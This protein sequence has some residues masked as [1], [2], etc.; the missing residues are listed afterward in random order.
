MIDERS[1]LGAAA[2]G[3]GLARAIGLHVGLTET[4]PTIEGPLL[5]DFH[6]HLHP[7]RIF[8]L[9]NRPFAAAIYNQ[10]FPSGTW[11]SDESIDPG[12]NA[13]EITRGLDEVR[14]SGK[15]SCPGCGYRLWYRFQPY[16]T[17]DPLRYLQHSIVVLARPHRCLPPDSS[18]QLGADVLEP[19]GPIIGGPDTLA[20]ASQLLGTTPTAITY[21]MI[22]DILI[23]LGWVQ[24]GA[25]PENPHLVALIDTVLS[26]RFPRE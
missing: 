8:V 20:L 19:T 11:L 1:P 23:E 10:L 9:P 17:D 4:D 2:F 24:P 6:V 26:Q 25:E 16:P 3:I 15:L 14:G 12:N 18:I 7:E 21:Q 22:K 5:G 13:L